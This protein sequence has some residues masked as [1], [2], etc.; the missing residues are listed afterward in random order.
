M[1]GE[2]C[3]DTHPAFDTHDPL[4]NADWYFGLVE[5]RALL[6]MQF[7]I[8]GQSTTWDASV[9][10]LRRILSITTQP[11]CHCKPLLVLRFENF[12]PERPRRNARAQRPD[13]KMV[14]FFVRPNNCFQWVASLHAPIV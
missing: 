5:V 11:I 14:A 13:P 4:H 8:S 3:N 7:E 10:K 6:D 2:A 9:S 12:R 1:V